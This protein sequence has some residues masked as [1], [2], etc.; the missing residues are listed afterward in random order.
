MLSQRWRRRGTGKAVGQVRSLLAQSPP[1]LH[2]VSQVPVILMDERTE[3]K[4][5]FPLFSPARELDMVKLSGSSYLLNPIII[6]KSR[7]QFSLR[8]YSRHII[9]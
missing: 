7:T 4:L 3:K 5:G 1:V 9:F 2:V 6:P 8:D